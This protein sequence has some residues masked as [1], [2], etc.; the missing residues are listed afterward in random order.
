MASCKNCI[1]DFTIYPDDLKMYQKFEVP[2][3][4]LCPDCRQQRRLAWRGNLAFYQRAC[5]LCR[6][7]IITQYSAD[8]PFPVYCPECW[9]GDGWDRLANGIVY[10]PARPFFEQLS[11]VIN[12]SPRLSSYT[13]KCDNCDYVD[14]T[15]G[16][17][18][19][20]LIIGSQDSE[21]CYYGEKFLKSKDCV[22]CNF[23]VECELCYG[24]IDSRGAYNCNFCQA[25]PRSTNCS[26]CYD[27]RGCSDC[28]G[29]WNLRNKQFYIFNKQYSEVEYQA[30]MKEYNLGSYQNLQKVRAQ[31]A[32][33]RASQA[34]HRFALI[35]HSTNVFGD[36]IFRSDN[37]WRCFNVMEFKDC[38]YASDDEKGTEM[39]DTNNC[40]YGELCYEVQDAYG[41]HWCRFGN[42]I[43]EDSFCDYSSHLTSCHDC[44]GCGSLHKASFCILNKQYGE[45]EY[46]KLRVQI[47]QQMQTTGEWGE[48]SPVHL[49]PYPYNESKASIFYPLSQE[50]VL[51]KGWRYKDEDAPSGAAHQL[52]AYTIPDDIQEVSD[53]ILAAVLPCEQCGK[54]Y[55]IIK[56]ELDFYRKKNIAAPRHCF[57]CRY[58]ALFNVRNFRQLYHRSCMNT[59]CKNEFETTY[60]PDR[61]EKVYCEECYQK[62]IY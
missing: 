58:L 22:D 54:Q 26:G 43:T 16:S 13:L 51:A 42:L 38:R 47:I 34:I 35:T 40:G 5:G 61:P 6:Q 41:N 30:K 33:S 31:F 46:K 37:C 45:T 15:A 36:Y 23:V 44:F 7:P 1:K 39:M 48:F 18:N 10:D 55:K 20:Y 14:K 21:D 27:C 32:A 49:S 52:P 59:G 3:P 17:K 12:S 29:C 2:Q 25:C 4:T 9:W 57:R 53:D 8:L 50:E 11:Q 62:E 24:C 56:Q 60:A 19:C 28:F